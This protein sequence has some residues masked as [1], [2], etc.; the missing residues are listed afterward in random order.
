MQPHYTHGTWPSLEKSV[1]TP[2]PADY[3]RFIEH[4]GTGVI[5]HGF[6][7]TN[8]VE[9][10]TYAT[11]LAKERQRSL[12]GFSNP[13]PFKVFPDSGGVFPWGVATDFWEFFWLREGHPND[14]SIVAACPPNDVWYHFPGKGM[15]QFL[16][17]LIQNPPFEIFPIRGT[18]R[19][20]DRDPRRKEVQSWEELARNDK[21]ARHRFAGL[22]EVELPVSGTVRPGVFSPNDPA[23]TVFIWEWTDEPALAGLVGAPCSVRLRSLLPP[24]QTPEEWSSAE[25]ANFQSRGVLLDRGVVGGAAGEIPW[26]QY[27]T[28]YPRVQGVINYPQVIYYWIANGLGWE[29]VGDATARLFHRFRPLFDDIAKSLVFVQS[30]A[31]S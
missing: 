14:W 8:Y 20:L 23:P 17:D 29:M 16:L 18:F 5:N 9:W 26:V 31:S 22:I 12:Q 7:V 21:V 6:F 10:P 2:F 15:T 13:F 25:A 4:Y 24:F 3:K 11:E 19:A 28:F 27:N 30:A 1:G